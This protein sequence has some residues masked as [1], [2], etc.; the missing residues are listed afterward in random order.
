MENKE[1]NEWLLHGYEEEKTWLDVPAEHL[2]RR[3]EELARS[4]QDKYWAG[5]ND[6]LRELGDEE[7]RL[8]RQVPGARQRIRV[9]AS[10]LWDEAGLNKKIRQN[11][12]RQLWTAQR[13][14]VKAARVTKEIEFLLE[15][16]NKVAAVLATEDADDEDME[17]RGEEK[18]E[19][20]ERKDEMNGVQHN[21][22]DEPGGAGGLTT[23]PSPPTRSP[24]TLANLLLSV[25]EGFQ[26]QVPLKDMVK[27]IEVAFASESACLPS[28]KMMMDNYGRDGDAPAG[29]QFSGRKVGTD[30]RWFRRA[31]DPPGSF[32]QVRAL[33]GTNELRFWGPPNPAAGRWPRVVLTTRRGAP[34]TSVLRF[35]IPSDGGP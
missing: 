5:V 35:W 29:S 8:E 30:V 14:V 12:E 17:E 1:T 11:V 10:I 15:L 34:G 2:A 23:I 25:R 20:N 4:W 13:V 32:R 28:A 22:G 33:A 18:G 26:E 3:A 24:V 16:S 7:P 31:P 6:R 27:A 21:D 19:D 9:A